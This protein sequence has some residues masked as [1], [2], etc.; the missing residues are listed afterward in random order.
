MRLFNRKKVVDEREQMEMFR[1]EH[2]MYWV[3]FW[4]LFASI[5]GQLILMRAAFLQV[6]GEWTVF[7]VM[8]IGLVIG[9]MKGG[10]FDYRHQP[11]WKYYLVYSLIAAVGAMGLVLANGLVRGYYGS[12]SDAWFSVLMVG[13]EVLVLTF[14]AMAAAGTFVKYRRKKLEAEY[15]EDEL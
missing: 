8:A 12:V 7:M 3:T 4:A 11:G 15:E 13:V 1:V 9:D 6:A 5:F 2:Y 10:H 14:A